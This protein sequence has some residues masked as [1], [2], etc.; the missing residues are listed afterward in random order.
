MIESCYQDEKITLEIREAKN[1]P[2][3]GTKIGLENVQ[4]MDFDKIQIDLMT[5]KLRAKME[6]ATLNS[7]R[8]EGNPQELS[9]DRKIENYL[10]SLVC[11]DCEP[12]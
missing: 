9:C 8:G 11:T 5:K 1:Q 6:I 12:P 7:T 2:P 10:A 3:Q 4:K